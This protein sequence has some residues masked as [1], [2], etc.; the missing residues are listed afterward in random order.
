MP[1]LEPGEEVIR[2]EA[3]RAALDQLL[4][5]A[6]QVLDQRE[7]E[8]ARPRPQ[9]AD[10]E[11]RDGLIGVD[12]P[13]QPLDVESRIAVAEEFHGHG[14]DA[15]RAGVL[16][17]GQLRKFA[18]IASR[19]VVPDLAHLGFNQVEVVEQPFRGGRDRLAAPHVGGEN[20][21]CVAK[22]ARIVREAAQQPRRAA[23]RVSRQGELRGQR[24][25][26]LLE[27]LDAE[28]FAVQRTRVEAD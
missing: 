14:V 3:S 1:A 28:E 25:R 6:A 11:R 15:C 5:Q 7:L 27:T 18:V 8:R 20:A 4:G 21:V 16:A 9:L 2:F 13:L 19:E 17:G 26:A 24:P 22:H 12:E 23:P 10:A